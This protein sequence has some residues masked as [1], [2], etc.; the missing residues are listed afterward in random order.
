MK[1]LCFSL[2]VL[3][4]MVAPANATIS[5]VD[6]GRTFSSR[7]DTH[8]GQ[9][10]LDGYEYMGRLQ[11]IPENPTLCPGTY[12][13]QKFDIVN[14]SDGLPVALVAKS[15]GC[16]IMEKV[17]VASTMINP[18]NVVGY[19]IVQDPK[20]KRHTK[21]LS[22][23]DPNSALDPIEN[24]SMDQTLQKY[25]ENAHVQPLGFGEDETS[26][27]VPP[28][29]LEMHLELAKENGRALLELP[30]LVEAPQKLGGL[31][32]INIALLHVGFATGDALLEILLKEDAMDKVKGGPRVLLNGRGNNMGARTVVF[33]MLVTFSFCACGCAC[34]LICVQTGFD[35]EPEPQA[36][37]RPVR[38]RLTL[39][40]VRS[41]FPSYHFSPDDHACCPT[42]GTCDAAAQQ[43]GYMELSDECTICLDEFIHGV[44]VRKLPCGHAF[45]STCIA[46]WLIERH[47]VCPLC[48]LDL[49][50]EEDESSSDS[51]SSTAQEQSPPPF[52]NGWFNNNDDARY[53]QLEVPSGAAESAP[54]LQNGEE[55]SWWPFSLE[56]VSSTDEEEEEEN[57]NHQSPLASAASA[58]SSLTMNVFGQRR[59]RQALNE[60]N[61]TELTEPLVPSS[62]L[63]EDAAPAAATAAAP[64]PQHS[65]E[66][67]ETSN[68]AVPI[69][70]TAAEI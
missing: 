27:L 46:R 51:D 55:R 59:R 13:N 58:L 53:T 24:L 12:P 2:S 61:L 34:L 40:E 22:L 6:S 32:Q 56:T 49:Y 19:L 54:L 68:S 3:L 44:R 8:V 18:A 48:K 15:G 63:E 69:E 66:L 60:E 17:K 5:F 65:V 29:S 42:D 21:M 67:P 64:P 47:A 26:I 41:R 50:I 30:Q 62:S 4:I 70:N 20:S 16:T 33:W 43:N 1:V 31:D 11:Y 39:E 36:P 14:P 28:E 7:Q 52:W 9:P 57:A 45:H 23:E 25:M 37:R 38:R 10:L 35:D